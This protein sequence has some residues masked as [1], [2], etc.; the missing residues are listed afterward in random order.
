MMDRMERRRRCRGDDHLFSG[1]VLI[2]IGVG[3]LMEQQGYGVLA[4]LKTQWPLAIAA[5]GVLRLL[6]ARRA[7]H[8]GSAG[9]LLV[10]AG[11]LYGCE[12]AYL[13][14]SYGNSWPLLLLAL[15][16]SKVV[17]GL[18]DWHAVGREERGA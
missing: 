10:L 5:L 9:F 8:V 2:A 12:T 14:M 6:T 17:S 13:G 18:W 11:W 7:R 1:L 4:F 15:G 16:L 3:A